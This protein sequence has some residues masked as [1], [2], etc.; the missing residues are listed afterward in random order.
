MLGTGLEVLTWRKDVTTNV[1]QIGHDLPDL[2]KG[3]AE[4]KHHPVLVRNP[5]LAC[6]L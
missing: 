2:L 4:T 1:D 6:P 3:F 5:A